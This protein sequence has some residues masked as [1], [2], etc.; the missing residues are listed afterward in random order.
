MRSNEYVKKT[1]NNA[2]GITDK[3][4]YV[5]KLNFGGVTQIRKVD[6]K[7]LKDLGNELYLC[8]LRRAKEVYNSRNNVSGRYKR[9]F[10]LIRCLRVG[11]EKDSI[12]VFYD[13]KAWHDSV[14]KKVAERY[15]KYN[16]PN[17]ENKGFVP[18]IIN[19][20][21]AV[22]KD[23]FYRD[24][25]YPNERIYPLKN[26]RNMGAGFGY[27]FV[28]KGID[29]FVKQQRNQ[30]QNIGIHVKLVKKYNGKNIGNVMNDII[31]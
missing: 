25:D 27:H 10:S 26:H 11:V 20:G 15:P 12:K 23:N 3:K 13:D 6:Y 31:I 30:S 19:D 2:L 9:T 21:F 4:Q 24:P 14:Y 28:E 1:I 18:L 17:S 7:Q 22:T 8:I 16:K 5:N 29:D